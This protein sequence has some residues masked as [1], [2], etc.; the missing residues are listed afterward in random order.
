MASDS[1][2]LKR[3]LTAFTKFTTQSLAERDLDTLLLNACVRARAGVDVSH[4]KLLEY[5]AGRDR[6]LLRAGVGWRE[7]LVGN[8]EVPPCLDT[9]IGHAFVLAEPVV[10]E[11]YMQETKFRY[12]Q[13]LKDHSCISSVNVPIQTDGGS[14]GVLEVD[15]VEARVFT[16]DDIS[17]LTGLGNTIAQ[18]IK[19]KRALAAAEKALEDKQLLLREMNHRIKNNLSLVSAILGLQ[20]RRFADANVREEFRAA[21]NRIR[22]L[23]LVHDR[24]Q[25]FSTS[26]TEVPAEPH[27]RELGEMLRSLLPPGVDLTMTCSGTIA[28]DCVEALT[29]VTNELV[30]N[31]AK[32]AFVGRDSGEIVVGYR[33]EG[34]GWRLWVS[35]NGT[36]FTESEVSASFGQQMIAAMATRL[37]AETSCVVDGGTRVD[38]V[39]GGNDG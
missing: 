28:G 17:F 13:I 20:S 38:V 27:F 9:P 39:C 24:L 34:A 12:P 36:G 37:H 35:D 10:I 29:L 1:E 21:A 22:N 26:V 18:A 7:G 16:D 15:H 32:Y 31:A 4:A 2:S 19:L 6:M 25:L 33:E 23:A 30:T 11:N 3:Q 8:Y 5:L 14:F